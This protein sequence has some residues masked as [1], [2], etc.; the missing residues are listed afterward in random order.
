MQNIFTDILNSATTRFAKAKSIAAVICEMKGYSWAGLYDV[1]QDSIKMI[2]CNRNEPAF[3]EFPRDKGLNGRAVLN[4]SAI[5]VN[6]V[7]NDPDYLTTFGETQ[8]ELIIPIISSD[9][10]EVVGTI[11]VESHAKDAFQNRDIEFLNDCA[12]KI[13]SLWTVHHHM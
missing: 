8:S 6:D 10:N 5:V 1:T 12:E 3:P 13:K 11:D 2:A 4:K 9:T 7:H